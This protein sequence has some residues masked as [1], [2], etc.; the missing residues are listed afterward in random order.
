VLDGIH[1]AVSRCE[2]LLE[3]GTESKKHEMNLNSWNQDGKSVHSVRSFILFE[4]DS[5]CSINCIDDI[6]DTDV[7]A[8]SSRYMYWDHE[9]SKNE[10]A[11]PQGIE[12][13]NLFMVTRIKRVFGPDCCSGLTI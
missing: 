12:N 6:T 1:S 8:D 3:A 7:S 9:G 13:A 10:C 11:R 2:S 4:L 5:A